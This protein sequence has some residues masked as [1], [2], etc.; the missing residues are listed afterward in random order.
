MIIASRAILSRLSLLW[1]MVTLAP[2]LSQD[3]LLAEQP[4]QR[5]LADRI[6]AIA[7]D[8]VV[9]KH[10]LEQ[11][12][13]ADRDYLSLMQQIPS[14]E[15]AEKLKKRKREMLD[16]LIDRRLMVSEAKRIGL[17]PDEALIQKRIDRT[18]ERFGIETTEEFD[19]VL[20]REGF[21][22][23]VLRALYV[24]EYM[25]QAVLDARVR[26]MIDVSDAQIVAYTEDNKGLLASAEQVN[27]A[28]ILFKVADPDDEL[29][30]A[31]AKSDAEQAL[32]RL[33]LGEPFDNVC[34]SAD[35]AHRG[36]DGL[37]F[38]SKDEM[39]SSLAEVAF[40]LETGD[41]SGIIKSPMGFHIVRLLERRGGGFEITPELKR[42]I[43]ETLYVR[44]FEKRYDALIKE[45]RAKSY[46]KIMLNAP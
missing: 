39:F 26:A 11:A 8:Q 16:L 27:F 14:S 46:I 33:Q 28:Q 4:A 13:S 5:Q 1:L 22:L 18:M 30:V 9:T 44:D 15:R 45:L 20:A 29:S 38:L 25:E 21:T 36:C 34:Q 23:P 37:G 7:N 40:E 2:M 35:N 17:K 19:Q 24:D 6:V 32:E 10:Q 31:A 42:K 3:V 12:L 41:V 43:R